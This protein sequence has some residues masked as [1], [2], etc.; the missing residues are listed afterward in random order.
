MTYTNERTLTER[1]TEYNTNTMC[2]YALGYIC[3]PVLIALIKFKVTAVSKA[4][5]LTRSF[6]FEYA[7]IWL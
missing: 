7:N 1:L 3:M 4:V 2:R 6:A 5:L